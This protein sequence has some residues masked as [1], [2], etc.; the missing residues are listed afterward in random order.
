[1]KKLFITLP[2]V[3]LALSLGACSVEKTDDGKMPEV[4]V[5]GGDLPNYDVETADVD[6]GTKKEIIEV[7]DVNVTMPDEKKK[8]TT[9]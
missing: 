5:K 8:S 3:A 6:V 4:D 1:M 2:A 7:P 9:E